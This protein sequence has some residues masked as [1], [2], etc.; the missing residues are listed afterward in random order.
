MN[1]LE[2]LE[3]VFFNYIL[4]HPT[5]FHR[6]EPI[7][8][9]NANLQFI[10]QRVRNFYISAKRPIVPSPKMIREMVRIDDPQG[11]VTDDFI[12]TLLSI[13]ISEYQQGK[14]DDWLRKNLQS[15]ST[16]T[17]IRSRMQEAM[18][19]VRNINPADVDSV[20]QAAS[21][22]KE[23]FGNSLLLNFEDNDLGLDFDDPLSH[24]QD[25]IKNKIP[26]GWKSLDE[27]TSGGY[28]LKTLTV[29]IGPSNSGKSLWLTNIAVNAANYGKNVLYVSLEM[30]ERKVMKRYGAM[31]LRIPI[32]EYDH[33]SKDVK[34]IESKI[35]ELKSRNAQYTK[36]SDLFENPHGR[37][38]VKEFPAG[39]ATVS[40]IDALVKA[41]IDK[42]GIKIDMVVVDYLTIMSPDNNKSG[43]LFT[44]GKQLSEGLRAIGQ[45]YNCVVVTAM[46]VGK[47][48]FG[49]GDINLQDTAESKAIVETADMM[50]GII[51][52]EEMRK[53]GKYILKL[54]KMRDG[55]FKWTKTHFDLD[56]KYLTIIN[57]NKMSE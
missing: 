51:R 53:H 11:K 38:F 46:Q 16:T 23:M 5:Y 34:Y 44:N 35:K 15:W 31:R 52:T 3:P 40:D 19:Y 13:N 7:A 8:F 25:T 26:T 2:S 48:N 41:Y 27:L 43:T 55:D 54:L 14:D 36:D 17:N 12:K 4:D 32:E 50:F 33:R 18:D 49:A 24:I 47:D 30:S 22:L 10:Y 28:D 9:K 42:K 6:V 20:E 29:I 56:K 39:S 37:F 45:K 57:D 1:N 21:R